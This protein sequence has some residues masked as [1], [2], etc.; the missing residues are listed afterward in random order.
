MDN[1]ENYLN[2]NCG[3]RYEDKNFQPIIY[4]GKI[5]KIERCINQIII[6]EPDKDNMKNSAWDLFET[7][8]SIKPQLEK[9]NDKLKITDIKILIPNF[10]VTYTGNPDTNAHCEKY[11]QLFIAEE[12]LIGEFW[13]IKNVSKYSFLELDQ[14]KASVA[15]AIIEACMGDKALTGI[16]KLFVH[17][18]LSGIDIEDSNGHIIKNTKI[19]EFIS[20]LHKSSEIR[21][22]IA[23]EKVAP[24]FS[25]ERFHIRLVPGITFHKE[26]TMTDLFKNNIHMK[27]PSWIERYR[28]N[29]G[30]VITSNGLVSGKKAALDFVSLPLIKFEKKT[31]L[32]FSLS[33]LPE[34]LLGS[35]YYID[36]SYEIPM[37]KIPFLEFP[38]SPKLINISQCNIFHEEVIIYIFGKIQQRLVS[39]PSKQLE[40]DI[41]GA[42]NDINPCESLTRVFSEYG[43]II[44]TEVTMGERL[45]VPQDLSSISES[46][47]VG[48]LGFNLPR[49]PII[50]PE[51]WKS[52]MNEYNISIPEYFIAHDSSPINLNDIDDW[53]NG[54]SEKPNDWSLANQ[55]R[56][57]PLYKI[58]NEMTQNKIRDLFKNDLKILMTGITRIKDKT[59]HCRV[60]FEKPL[61]SD[62]YRIIGS[63]IYN[64]EKL[65]SSVKFKNL[66]TRGFLIILDESIY[67]KHK[68]NLEV[69][70][71]LIGK[72][73][74]VGYFSNFTRDIKTLFSKESISISEKNTSH[75]MFVEE[76]LISGFIIA[77]YVQYPRTNYEIMIQTNLKSWSE[78]R[79]DLDFTVHLFDIDSPHEFEINLYVINPIQEEHVIADIILEDEN[80]VVSNER[81]IYWKLIGHELID[82]DFIAQE[83][84]CHTINKNSRVTGEISEFDEVKTIETKYE[85]INSIAR[86][87]TKINNSHGETDPFVD[88]LVKKYEYFSF[89]ILNDITKDESCITKLACLTELDKNIVLKYIKY[90]DRYKNKDDYYKD[91]K[92]E[93]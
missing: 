65:N 34:G 88:S 33:T 8:F 55:P 11:H 56:L 18:G 1:L 67:Q 84:E 13:T 57:V 38:S 16:D 6:Y 58:L 7:K 42:I 66:S 69:F 35:K 22:I 43:H 29:Y 27:L 74:S 77:T 12:V 45:Y 24:T 26:I 21:N 75:S 14:F 61:K 81:R 23:Y 85:I 87:Q 50:L 49:N 2:L 62:D 20:Q 70:W 71:Q 78:K 15:W 54:L 76:K 32:K 40:E 53:L 30:I 92:R 31:K 5:M 25:D 46:C 93:V 72:P 37:D 63:A 90:I 4:E 91:F 59:R 9:N 83:N 89:K 48:C 73:K 52:I 64:N 51:N 36:Y 47:G 68:R 28:L 10:K 79:I 3:L 82:R 86:S 17:S 80:I 41:N 39:Q 19:L 60:F 44:C